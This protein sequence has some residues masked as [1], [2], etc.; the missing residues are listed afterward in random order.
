MESGD[1]VAVQA[2]EPLDELVRM[3]ADVGETGANLSATETGSARIRACPG[4]AGYFQ[5]LEVWRRRV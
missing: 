1:L 3:A 5:L 2:A 4:L